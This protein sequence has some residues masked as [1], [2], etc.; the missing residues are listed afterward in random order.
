[1]LRASL[2]LAVGV[3]N[4]PAMA[5][6]AGHFCMLGEP[7][8]P[9]HVGVGSHDPHTVSSMR[10]ADVVSS[11]HIPARIKPERG[12]VTEDDSEAA[13]SEHWG[14]LHEHVGGSNLANDASEVAPE[15]TALALDAGAAPGARDVLAREPAADDVDVSA[16][17][18]AGEGAD[19]IPD[20]ERVELSVS[21]TR[22]QDA[23]AV[24][25]NL[26]SADGAPSKEEPSQDAS[27]CACKKCQLTHGTSLR[28][29]VAPRARRGRVRSRAFASPP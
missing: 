16:P 18:R 25:I 29:L 24:G 3:A 10:S 7:S 23:P 12:Q 1:V 5:R 28:P 22:E 27:A 6:C 8:F 2:P 14:V 9:A 19:V 21:L 26:D 11:Q 17:G 13:R 20:G 4:I 15:P